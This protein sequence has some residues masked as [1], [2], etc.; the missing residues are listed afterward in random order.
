MNQSDPTEEQVA[1]LPRKYDF[2]NTDFAIGEKSIDA[3]TSSFNAEQRA[4][5]TRAL[6]YEL[7]RQRELSRTKKFGANEALTLM[8][9]YQL[10]GECK[11]NGK[12]EYNYNLQGTAYVGVRI[13]WDLHL[14]IYSRSCQ[15]FSFYIRPKFHK[16]I[17]ARVYGGRGIINI[18]EADIRDVLT[19]SARNAKIDTL[20]A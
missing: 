12:A 5:Y 18:N 9:L 8:R 16:V 2:A 7:H 17:K 4:D 14:P 6:F 13:V 20:L 11:G 19:P 10:Y 1:A 3:P 15:D